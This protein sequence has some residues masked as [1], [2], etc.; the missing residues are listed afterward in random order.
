MV[1]TTNNAL[2]DLFIQLYTIKNE[3]FVIHRHSS[4]N[5]EFV[6]SFKQI[7]FP[8]TK[9]GGFTN[10]DGTVHFYT[11]VNAL[12]QPGF[13]LL[14]YGCGRGEYAYDPINYRKRLRIFQHKCKRVVGV[15]VDEDAR[16]NPFID[17]FRLIEGEKFN[18][19]G[20]YYRFVYL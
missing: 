6:K 16:Q 17:E 3:A 13:V 20:S 8:E 18:L 1:W 5:E 10:I 15:D 12:I 2:V 11:R 7:Y 9:F 19:A 4:K 14:D